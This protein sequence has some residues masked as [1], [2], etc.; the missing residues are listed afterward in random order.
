M[1]IAGPG[2]AETEIMGL[3]HFDVQIDPTQKH[4]ETRM[5]ARFT[6]FLS[7]VNRTVVLAYVNG[8]D[9]LDSHWFKD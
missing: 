3:A 2:Q 5:N 9:P 6:S 8:S 1:F 7:H 4:L